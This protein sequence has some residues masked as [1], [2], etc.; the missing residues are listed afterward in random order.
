MLIS[1][2][3]VYENHDAYQWKS[4]KIKDF[5]LPPRIYFLQFITLTIIYTV[6]YSMLSHYRLDKSSSHAHLHQRTG[7]ASQNH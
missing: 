3:S 2:Q 4:Q 5:N 7:M 1:L 6:P